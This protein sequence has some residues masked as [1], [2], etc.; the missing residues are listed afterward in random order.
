MLIESVLIEGFWGGTTA[1]SKI[2]PDVTIFIGVNGTGKTTFI[3]LIT[4]V[5]TAD[6][7]Q[8]D[9]YQFSNVKIVLIDSQRKSQRTINVSTEKSD[10]PYNVYIYK[11]GTSKYKT[12]SALTTHRRSASYQRLYGS[13]PPEA[14]REHIELK[15]TL[16]NLVEVSS[17]SVHRQTYTESVDEDPR[18]RRTA[19][20]D[21]LRQL[22][23]QFAKYQLKLETQINERSRVFQQD[24][25]ASLLYNAELDDFEI[26]LSTISQID[27]EKEQGNLLRAFNE[28]GL[29]GKTKQIEEHFNKLRSAVQ[30]LKYSLVNK[31]EINVE[32]VLPLPLIR[33]TKR[34]V[35]LLK[36]SEEDKKTINE[37]LQKFFDA[38]H[39]FMGS[40][41]NFS[42]KNKTG[43]LTVTINDR[44]ALSLFNLSSGEKQLL[45][46]FMEVLLQEGK[47]LIFIADEPELSLHISWQEKLLPALRD[48]NSNAQLI[49]A[50]HSPDIVADYR[51][52]VIDMSNVVGKNVN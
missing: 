36:V 24:A 21:R 16:T 44:E 25:I 49:I 29:V 22:L 40:T 7:Q 38:L 26:E 31:Q 13:L 9:E 34:I 43:E 23:G 6:I 2:Y 5:L 27:L 50:T 39:N 37:P 48:L 28:L 42:T 30:S 32:D 45:I 11:I 1:Y 3:N 33:R 52:N 20:D 41:K 18:Q 17:I 10:L 12:Y 47:N 51:E 8:L 14:R 15:S 19:V 4:A 35:D 46:Q